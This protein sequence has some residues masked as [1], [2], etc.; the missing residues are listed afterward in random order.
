MSQFDDFDVEFQNFKNSRA[1]KFKAQVPTAGVPVTLTPTTGDPITLAFIDVPGKRDPD[2]PNNINDA[3]KYSF[4]GGLTF[5]TLLAGESVYIPG[6]F[7]D[8]QIDTNN[9]GTWYRVALWS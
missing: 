9:N 8:L 3:I 2:N 4:D 6:V 7:T 1:E 5:F